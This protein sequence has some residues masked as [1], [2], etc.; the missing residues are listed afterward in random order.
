MIDPDKDLDKDGEIGQNLDDDWAAALAEQTA[1]TQ[2][3][4]ADGLAD[5]ADDWAA[6]LAEQTAATA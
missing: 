5:A 3:T 1:H 6:A 4:Q 2:S